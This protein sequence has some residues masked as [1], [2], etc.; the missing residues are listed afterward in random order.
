[1]EN[2]AFLA[3]EVP[4]F[5]VKGKNVKVISEPSDFHAALCTRAE[6]VKQRAVFATL[7][8]G[9]GSKEQTLVDCVSKGLENSDG[10]VKVKFLLD[11]SRG[12][13]DVKGQSSCTK[14]LPL[15]Q[16][17]KVSNNVTIIMITKNSAQ[18][19]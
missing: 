11:Y 15:V 1:M 5:A 7:Y 8:L 3:K 16:K 14:L 12:T 4:G 10:K 18:L 2:L 13:R 17:Y 6:N 19:S 9:T